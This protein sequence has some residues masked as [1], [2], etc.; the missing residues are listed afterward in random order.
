[1]PEVQPQS[2]EEMLLTRSGLVFLSSGSN[3]P[4]EKQLRAFELEL[5]N[6]GYLPSFRLR[7]RMKSCD[8]DSLGRLLPWCV[9]ALLKQ[10]GGDQ[11]HTPLFRKFPD[12]V[13]DDTASLWWS[14]VLVHFLQA[15]DQP[16]LFCSRVGTTHVLKPCTHVVCDHCFD[17]SNYSACPVCEHHV[18]ASSP[19]FRESPGRELP[20]EQVRYKIL[21]L[22]S[23]V[24][25]DSRALFCSLCRRTQALSPQDRSALET[26]ISA[27]QLDVVSWLPEE[28]PLRENIAVVFGGLLRMC[29]ASAVMTHAR[30]YMNTATD[31]LRLIAVMSGTD[32][33]LQAEIVNRPVQHPEQPGRFWGAIAKLLG[34]QALGTMPGTVHVPI[35]I[36]RFKVAKMSRSLRRELFAL[37]ETMPPEQMTE[38]ML[39]HRSYWV[40]VG[41]F[42]HPH[43]YADRFPNVAKAFQILRKKA[44][45]GTPAPTFRTW[46]GKLDEAIASHNTQALVALLSERPGEFGRRL[47]HTIRTTTTDADARAVTQAF[48]ELVP[49]LATPLLVTLLKHLPSRANK[50]PVRVYWP[51]GR[52]AKGASAVDNRQ[53]I[54]SEIAG[55]IVKAIRKELLARFAQQPSFETGLIDAKL[56]D[57][58]APFNERTAS[59]SAV[60]LPRGS[61]VPACAGKTVRLFL[62]WCQP[63]KGGSQTDLDLSVAFYD[64]Q[65]GYLGVCSYYELRFTVGESLVA[66]S[67]GDLRDAPWPDGAT[68]FVDLHTDAAAAIGARF[69]VMVVNSYRGMPFSKLERGFAGIMLRDDVGGQHFDPRTVELRFS[70]DGENGIYLPLVLDLKQDMLHWLDVQSKGQFAL[71]NVATSNAS[72]SQLCP[73]LL[74]YFGAGLRPSM[75]DLGLLHAAARCRRVLVRD[76]SINEFVRQADEPIEEFHVRILPGKGE[77]VKT[78]PQDGRPMLAL[79]YRGDLGLPEGSDIYSLFRDQ[80]PSTLAASDLFSSRC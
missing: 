44:P 74:S 52:I 34:A 33:S 59:V 24:I 3:S 16:C 58:M 31:L 28:I 47:D 25:S 79:L 66:Q 6:I 5:A 15:Q 12:G 41:E 2:V 62:H 67:S 32:G 71:N 8:A 37:L 10:V 77:R 21:E 17:G 46:Y 39:R 11:K 65:W 40:W 18:D 70:L 35:Q 7:S 43:E 54:C 80:L 14:K 50:A 63:Q 13:P 20:R 57:V 19:F 61:R 73:T 72:I 69:A 51:K 60:N 68:E 27:H 64:D 30:R 26:I 36:R 38:D 48:G 76:G 22:G 53:T 78:L 49:R 56:Q 75:F 42:L 45:D 4:E 9:N 1:M 55:P 29:P 23:D